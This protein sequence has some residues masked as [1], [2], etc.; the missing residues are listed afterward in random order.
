MDLELT[1]NNEFSRGENP[2]SMSK[3]IGIGIIEL[4]TI[5]NKIKPDFVITV[6]DRYET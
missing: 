6:G 1:Q 5:L 4:S 2:L 3:T